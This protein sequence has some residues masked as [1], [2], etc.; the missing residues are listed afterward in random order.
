MTFA[1]GPHFVDARFLTAGLWGLLLRQSREVT[2]IDTPMLGMNGNG[3]KTVDVTYHYR[4]AN[5]P[6][7]AN[8]QEMKT[9][10]PRM[11]SALG[12]NASDN[13]TLVMT[14]DHW[15]FVK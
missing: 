13:A 15:E 3:A 9:A 8:S 12:S 14:G 11:A 5:V 7:W 2:S 1:K 10:Y 6:G 4:V